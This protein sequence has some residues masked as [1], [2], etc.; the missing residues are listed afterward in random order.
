MLASAFT[1]AKKTGALFFSTGIGALVNI[2][3]NIPFVYYFGSKGAACATA[4]SCI[5]VWVIRIIQTNRYILIKINYVN[6]IVS[7]ILLIIQAVLTSMGICNIWITGI[8]IFLCLLFINRAEGKK[9]FTV[10]FSV[11]LKLKNRK[12]NT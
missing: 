1:S 3:L 4:I 9:L 5:V 6:Q 11:I 7:F 2:A 8:L 10:I 12:G